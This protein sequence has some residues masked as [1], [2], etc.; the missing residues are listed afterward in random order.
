MLPNSYILIESFALYYYSYLKI[1]SLS[2]VGTTSIG[3]QVI[4]SFTA[5]S[6]SLQHLIQE[7]ISLVYIIT[8]TYRLSYIYK[9]S[10]L[11]ISLLMI[12]TSNLVLTNTFTTILLIDTL[13]Y[14]I[15]I[16]QTT[17]SSSTGTNQTILYRLITKITSCTLANSLSFLGFY[18][19]SLSNQPK[20]FNSNQKI[21]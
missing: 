20:L 13:V 12:F 5:T 2:L 14:S 16:V 3:I 7:I 1:K 21:A 10:L 11:T 8:N 4:I 19:T 9:L 18:I 15:P 6:I 17:S